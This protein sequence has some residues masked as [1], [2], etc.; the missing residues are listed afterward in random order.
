MLQPS[1]WKN[2][3]ECFVC[4]LNLHLLLPLLQPTGRSCLPISTT[5]LH[6]SM[7]A[8]VCTKKTVKS[9]T[10]R[11]ALLVG[12]VNSHVRKALRRGQLERDGRRCDALEAYLPSSPI[13]VYT[14]DTN[15]ASDDALVKPGRHFQGNI[16]DYRRIRSLFKENSTLSSS[17]STTPYKQFHFIFVDYIHMPP[18]Y[19]DSILSDRFFSN[20]LRGLLKDN[21]LSDDAEIW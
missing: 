20:T 19:I 1:R 18:C 6:S 11:N 13:T 16:T 4:F 5:F 9:Q 17:S 14:L 21:V 7:R 8:K 3:F 2:V 10:A 12:M 15:R